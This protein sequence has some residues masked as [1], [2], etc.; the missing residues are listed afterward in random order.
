MGRRKA[1]FNGQGEPVFWD[2]TRQDLQTIARSFS[3]AQQN[4]VAFNLTKSHGDLRTLIVPTDDLISTL[5]QVIA[6]GDELWCS[7]YVTPEE[8]LWLSNPAMK[9]SPGIKPD[10]MDGEGRV[11]P[12]QLIH[13]AVTDQPVVPR[14]GAFIAMANTQSGV[15]KMDEAILGLF[16]QIFE[17]EEMPL[18]E[19]VT[20]DNA[21][22]VLPILVQQ[23]IGTEETEGETPP[24]AP[25]GEVIPAEDP[26]AMAMANAAAPPWA[27]GLIDGISALSG[28]I[29]AIENGG[30]RAAFEAK[31]GALVTAGRLSQAQ[32]VAMTNAAAPSGFDTSVLDILGTGLPVQGAPALGRA[33]RALSNAQAA[34]V[35]KKADK[36]S[37]VEAL[38]GSKRRVQKPLA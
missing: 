37:C 21:M 33:A 7:S 6:E 28:R 24:E 35:V 14:Q 31:A 11:Y 10:F 17:Y 12:L 18:P 34:P 30:K 5:D 20:V 8:A 36:D 2:V 1:G 25:A 27:K 29:E 32:A 15:K 4:G 3:N 23:L 13:V 16:Q 26:V 22:D 19:S 38:I 9:V